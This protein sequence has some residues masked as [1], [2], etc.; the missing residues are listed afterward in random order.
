MKSFFGIFVDMDVNYLCCVFEVCVS[1]SDE[2]H[3]PFFQLLLTLFYAFVGLVF[4]T[5][6]KLV[7][8]L[9]QLLYVQPIDIRRIPIHVLAIYYDVIIR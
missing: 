3:C 6:H 4:T 9:S 1:C 8:L 2:W 7:R 5:F